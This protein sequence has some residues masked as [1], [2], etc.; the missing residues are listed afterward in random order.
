MGASGHYHFH[1]KVND[2]AEVGSNHVAKLVY[3]RP[4]EQEAGQEVEVTFV[5]V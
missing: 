2:D 1:V 5:V 4:W 3:K